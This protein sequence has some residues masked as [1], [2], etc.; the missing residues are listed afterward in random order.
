VEGEQLV[1]HNAS[2]GSMDL[3]SITDI[4]HSDAALGQPRKRTFLQ[5]I[6]NSSENVAE[7][8]PPIAT[9]FVPSGTYLMLKG[10]QTSL[11]Q[12]YGMEG[13]EGTIFV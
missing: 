2:T 12:R 5:R 6:A 3:V 4:P 10:L 9:V 1:L 13:D 7:G 11:Q 8:S